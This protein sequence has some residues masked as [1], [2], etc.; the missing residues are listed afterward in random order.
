VSTPRL[1]S[2]TTVRPTSIRKLH[3]QERHRRAPH[4]LCGSTLTDGVQ[5]TANHERRHRDRRQDL[6]AALDQPCHL[7]SEPTRSWFAS[8]AS[9]LHGRRVAVVHAV[10]LASDRRFAN[11]TVFRPP[12]EAC[13]LRAR[14]G[15]R[16][17]GPDE[18]HSRRPAGTC[19]RPRGPPHDARLRGASAHDHGDAVGVSVGP[20]GAAKRAARALTGP[21]RFRG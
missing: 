3:G 17:A 20:H 19:D 5:E 4:G 11:I 15:L 21:V 1:C 12:P 6:S 2:T 18:A 16:R 9:V 7:R 13:A 14:A 10:M 8:G